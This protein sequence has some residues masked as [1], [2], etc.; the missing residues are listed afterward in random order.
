SRLRFEG[1]KGCFPISHDKKTLFQIIA[2]RV[3]AASALAGRAL[4]VA[5]L[6]SRLN[7]KETINYFAKHAYFGLKPQKQLFF[8]TQELWPLLDLQGNLFLQAP[9]QIAKGPN[10]NGGVFR[11]FYSSGLW[12]LWNKMGI[13]HLQLIPVDNALAAPFDVELIGFHKKHASEIT[14]K[15]CTRCDPQEKVGI[16]CQVEKKPRVIEYFEIPD[17]EKEA[18]EEGGRLK[19]SIASI[20]LF[21][22]S[23]SFMKKAAHFELP[24][25]FVKK[26]VK[27]FDSSGKTFF[28]KEPNAFKFEEFIF[29]VLPFAE[30]C[31]VLIYPRERCFAPLKNEES[32]K[33]V[34]LALERAGKEMR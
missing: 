31:K 2:E 27:Y 9:S 6:T 23:L 26:A 14:I 15:T 20:G 32:I 16:L 22:F 7:H 3:L 33:E 34:R 29:D 17:K 19:Y 21:A 30:T 12:E 11:Y 24:I 8:F 4:P 1:P 5:I 13:E 18:R 28:P 10:G 25:H